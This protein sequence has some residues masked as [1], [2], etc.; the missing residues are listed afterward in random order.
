MT[1]IAY[2]AEAKAGTHGVGRL[3]RASDAAPPRDRIPRRN[4]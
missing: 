3:G 1:D 2:L 4:T